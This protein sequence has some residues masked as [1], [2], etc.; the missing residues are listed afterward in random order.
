M[1]GKEDFKKLEIHHL[2]VRVATWYNCDRWYVPVW[3]AWTTP[4]AMKEKFD[5]TRTQRTST[6]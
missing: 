4:T 1:A 6:G 3:V 5:A 2:D